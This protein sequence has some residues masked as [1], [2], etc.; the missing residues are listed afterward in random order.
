MLSEYVLSLFSFRYCKS[1]TLDKTVSMKELKA[2]LLVACIAAFSTGCKEDEAYVITCSDGPVKY[3][4]LNDDLN[5]GVQLK[6]F[7]RDSSLTVRVIQNADALFSTLSYSFLR[8]KIDFKKETLLVGVVRTHSLGGVVAQN[9]SS[10]CTSNEIVLQTTIKIGG[11]AAID[12]VPVCAI[13]P[14]ISD[15]TSVRVVV[16]RIE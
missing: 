4:L 15:E 6:D 11:G 16:D 8:S 12:H 13:V 10:N 14:K 9:V 5:P 7:D 3:R 2:I 1:K